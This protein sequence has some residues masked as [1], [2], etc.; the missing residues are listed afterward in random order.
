MMISEMNN[1]DDL[2]SQNMTEF[3]QTDIDGSF[4]FSLNAIAIQSLEK[5]LKSFNTPPLD[6]DQIS[7]IWDQ[8]ISIEKTMDTVAEELW[9]C[10]WKASIILFSIFMSKFHQ[11]FMEHRFLETTLEL[12][13][14]FYI[15]V[16]SIAHDYKV[17]PGDQSKFSLKC[18][19]CH[20]KIITPTK[21]I[22]KLLFMAPMAISHHLKMLSS[23]F[24]VNDSPLVLRNMPVLF[25]S[26][27][28]YSASKSLFDNA[29]YEKLKMTQKNYSTQKIC[30]PIMIV[31]L[32]NTV[33]VRQLK[34]IRQGQKINVK[35][36][37]Q[38]KE[39]SSFRH[40]FKH[41]VFALRTFLRLGCAIELHEKIANEDT[42]LH[43]LDPRDY[44]FNGQ[45]E[46]D[47]LFGQG[48]IN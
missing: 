21:L 28:N 43:S 13:Q 30:V 18:L 15:Q 11:C 17:F 5:Y 32:G 36:T 41:C 3:L 34:L 46:G 12:I 1:I 23:I 25:T 22:G 29:I 20:G 48:I 47:Y 14:Q 4:D 35:K 9:K 6:I 40:T 27:K 10:A 2:F 31:G 26:M 33:F 42:E 19:L 7:S 16:E 8:L 45:A 37:F 38:E 24:P 39:E 44:L